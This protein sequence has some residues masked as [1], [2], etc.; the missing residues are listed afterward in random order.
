MP[1]ILVAYFAGILTVLAPCI[2]PLL[3]IVIGGASASG[4]NKKPTWYHPVII[5]SSLAVSVILFTLLLKATTAL[6][7]VP[8]QVW[9]IVSGLIVIGIGLTFLLPNLW[10]KLMVFTRFEILT[11]KSFANGMKNDGIMRDISIGA[12]LGPV[13]SSCS[14]TYALI[15]ALVLP[16]S[17]MTGLIY[18]FAYAIGL[19]T[20]LFGLAFMGSALVKKLSWL[21]DPS[22]WFKRVIGIVFII[23]GLVVIIGLDKDLQT[24]V[25]ESGWYA[26]IEKFEQ[27]LNF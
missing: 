8:Q 11:N 10:A 2:L 7:G 19:A 4:D 13:F 23:V 15:V 17:F 22:G 1:Q 14:P 27:K 6:L 21:S 24:F 3:P 5:T 12:A 25:L 20:V 16:T 9:S 18:L 26:P